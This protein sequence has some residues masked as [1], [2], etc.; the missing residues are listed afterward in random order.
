VRAI[1]LLLLCSCAPVAVSAPASIPF[2]RIDPELAGAVMSRQAAIAIASRRLDYEA[3]CAFTLNNCETMIEIA[4]EE[5][6]D[7]NAYADKT[8]WWATY[9]PVILT[10]GTL[11]ALF[12][13]F[14]FGFAV[15][16]AA[17]K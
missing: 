1:A 10:V 5:A 3:K 8:A 4:R 9:G 14:G 6:R 11:A 13:G 7:A 15:A 12:G 16:N 2:V 17:T